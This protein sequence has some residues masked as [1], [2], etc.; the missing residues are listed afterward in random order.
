M[1]QLYHIYTTAIQY[2][3]ESDWETGQI[4]MFKWLICSYYADYFLSTPPISVWSIVLKQSNFVGHIHNHTHCIMN[5]MLFM[6]VIVK[7][8]SNGLNII[9][10]CLH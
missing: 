4:Q 6:T 7:I 5:E 1:E 10:R 2:N 3:V 9:L 8:E